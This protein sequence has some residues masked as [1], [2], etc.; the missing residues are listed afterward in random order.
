[1]FFS[2]KTEGRVVLLMEVQS[3]MIRGSLIWLREGKLPEILFTDSRAVPYKAHADTSYFIKV[4]IRALGETVSAVAKHLYAFRKDP[5]HHEVPDRIAEAHYA[6]S[7]PWIVS[8][9]RTLSVTFD[10]DSKVTASKLDSILEAEREKLVPPG[11]AETE[12]IEEKVFDVRLNG[13]S[14]SSWQDKECRE[15]EISYA[16]TAAS[17]NITKKFREAVSELI[18]PGRVHFHSSLLL[19]YVGFAAIMP[20]RESYTLVHIHGELTDVSVVKHRSCV[21]FG[22]YPF[23]S[24]TLVEKIGKAAN[25]DRGSAESLLS[26]TIGG[27][28]DPE[29]GETMRPVIGEL[30]LG[31]ASG[32]KGLF[33]QA[34]FSGTVPK[35][36]IITSRMHEAFF[37]DSFKKANPDAD[38]EAL[39]ADMVAEHAVFDRL[40]EHNRLVGTYAS[41]IHSLDTGNVTS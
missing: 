10:H 6:L 26:L 38:V 37:V 32:F 35:H 15:L 36:T 28:L 24:Q 16:L 17:V 11:A 18:R 23:G 3:S 31:W 19:M 30:G 39:S 2:R 22:S 27:K 5:D 13:Y 29:H 21:F 1:M 41:A 4:N 34:P 20:D 9:A 12:I 14:V 7:S 33:K 40:V 8:Q 25:L